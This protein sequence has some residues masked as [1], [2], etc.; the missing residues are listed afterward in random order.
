MLRARRWLPIVAL[1]ALLGIMVEV[2]FAAGSESP[3]SEETY[4]EGPLDS[5]RSLSTLDWP[6]NADEF[7]GLGVLA[8]ILCGFRASGL[9]RNPAPRSKMSARDSR[10]S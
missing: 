3:V 4:R 6:S 5:P 9:A 8:A 10:M 2:G 1:L 7:L